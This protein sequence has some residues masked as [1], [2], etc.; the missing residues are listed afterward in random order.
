M[1]LEEEI[2][3]AELSG[4]SVL[5]CFDANSKMGPNHIPEDPHDISENGKVLEG[6]S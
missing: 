1:T 3:K 4:R 6:M 2:S 5:L